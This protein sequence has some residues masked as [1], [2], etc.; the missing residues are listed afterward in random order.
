LPLFKYLGFDE[1]VYPAF[2]IPGEGTLVARPGE[3][4]E[5]NDVPGDGRWEPADELPEK[6][7]AAKPATF[8]SDPA[9]D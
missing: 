6:P 2:V 3:V 4:R 7:K 9:E 5:L 1:R 8:E